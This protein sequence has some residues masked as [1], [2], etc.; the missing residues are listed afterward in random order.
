MIAPGAG[1]YGADARIARAREL[2]DRHAESARVLS[3]YADV[4]GVQQ[5]FLE[6]VGR[7]DAGVDLAAVA[8]LVPEFLDWLPSTAPDSLAE[9]AIRLKR[10]RANGWADLFARYWNAER[11]E[12]DD[13]DDERL[14]VVEALLQPFAEAVATQ[15]ADGAGGACP[16]CGGRP[17]VAVLR[18][19][20]HGTRRTL[21]CGLCLSEFAA[22]RL[23]CLACGEGR[24]E[25]LSVYKAE[26]FPGVRIDSCDTCRSYIKAI[27][28]SENGRAVPVVDD[29]A[30]LPLDLWAGEQG[31]RKAR[32]N[33]LRI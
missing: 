17:V 5:S 32:P 1:L 11:H 26:Q 28:L 25:Q 9:A 16:A 33:L 22:L 19:Q 10:D 14:F 24:F 4:V 8:G 20:G 13:V 18:E 23:T 30:T 12:L 21:V 15:G 3:F 7:P 2:A 6:R 27:D 29:L 31:Y